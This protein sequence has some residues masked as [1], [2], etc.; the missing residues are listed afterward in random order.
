MAKKYY[1]VKSGRVSGIYE[2]WD[3]AKEQVH[4]YKQAMYKSFKT[5]EEAQSYMED[6]AP[7]LKND[8]TGKLLAYVDGSFSNIIKKYAA[9]AVYVIDDEVIATE[10][11][12]Y[13]D[14][15]LVQIR[16]VAGEIKASMMAID[17][18][19][20]KGY[21]EVHIFFDYEGIRSWAMGY[22]KTNIDATKDYKKFFDAKKDEVKIH[23]HKVEAHTG[24]KYNELADS[25]AKKAL[26]K[27]S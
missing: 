15:E 4:G 18:A 26:I 6:E 12:A 21:D 25:L 22:W 20:D 13:D 27:M 5:L 17:Y 8:L 16:N 1:A 9:A 24:D 3:E 23:F 2:T 14:K 7:E 11:L 19:I 10:S